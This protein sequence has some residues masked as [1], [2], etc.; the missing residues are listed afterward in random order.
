M[1]AAPRWWWQLRWLAW[2]DGARRQPLRH[3]VPLAAWWLCWIVIPL[4]GLA[5]AEFA[6]A[7]M[8]FLASL[9]VPLTLL[10]AFGVTADVR[11]FDIAAGRDAW[12]WPPSFRPPRVRW[13][14]RLEWLMVA[15]WPF[16]LAIAGMLL[17]IGAS[18]FGRGEETELWMMAALALITA[19]LVLW[20]RQGAGAR[21][22]SV[23]SARVRRARGLAALSWAG[24]HE[25][26]DR[27]HL[28]RLAM[29]CMPI[30][31]AAPMGADA[32]QV[33]GLVAW[34]LG[35]VFIAQVLGECLR[36]QT[37]VQR[38]LP[39]AAMSPLALGVRVWRIV[40][41]G[42]LVLLTA[43]WLWMTP[44]AQPAQDAR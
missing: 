20:I 7:T 19:L 13:L 27:L 38:W 14:L 24:I 1:K 16:G 36:I 8:R 37:D 43:W 23:A 30:L 21:D 15:R 6:A 3:V 4:I 41:L 18:S 39:G 11:R 42:V 9:D 31:L 28:R 5:N 32:A 12:L 34:F 44:A 25:A 33:A 22:R 40:A 2:L 26:A 17:T 10:L 35:A 29:L